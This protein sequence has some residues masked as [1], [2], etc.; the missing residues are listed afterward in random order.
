LSKNHSCIV[1]AVCLWSLSCWKVNLHPS[2]RS[3]VLWRRFS[4]R[5]SLYFAPFIFPLILT[6]IPVPAGEKHYHSMMLPPPCFT[7]GI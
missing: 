1:L 5:I 2:Q 3:W 6:S 4:S 7:L